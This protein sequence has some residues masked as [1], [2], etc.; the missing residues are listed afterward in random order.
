MYN[1]AL[2]E[3]Y[4]AM[5]EAKS[6][7]DESKT[8]LQIF[9]ASHGGS[10]ID[11]GCGT[12]GHSRHLAKHFDLVFA[13]DPSSEM[14]AK[15]RTIAKDENL[16]NVLLHLGSIE[17]LAATNKFDLAIAMF[18]VVN[19]ILDLKS[20]ESLVESVAN[21]LVPGGVW[22]FDCW[23]GNAARVDVPYE[24]SSR[25]FEYQEQKLEL[26]TFSET[27][28]REGAVSMRLTLPNWTEKIGNV[29]PEIPVLT[30]R[31][32]T[33]DVIE[34]LLLVSGFNEIQIFDAKAYPKSPDFRE[35]K[36]LLFKAQI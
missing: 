35:T 26:V 28:F 27:D 10:A 14:I 1:K 8:V 17:S 32:W 2:V 31:L 9:G 18:N 20:L 36:R 34:E 29:Q 30:H 33:P 21:S 19:H 12:L 25:T 4:D 23:N 5:Y 11:I 15:A 6:Y 24:S 22:I 3:L 13:V 7:A 16:G